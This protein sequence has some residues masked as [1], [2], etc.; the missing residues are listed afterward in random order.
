MAGGKTVEGAMSVSPGVWVYQN[1]DKGLAAE[2]GISGTKYY[3][4]KSRN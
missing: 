1:T 4:D 2:L 3:K